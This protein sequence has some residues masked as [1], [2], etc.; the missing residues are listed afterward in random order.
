MLTTT[1]TT[2]P[3]AACITT[4]VYHLLIIS[5]SSSLTGCCK[6]HA[7]AFPTLVTNS[8]A[9]AAD[10]TN[11][12]AAA[13]AVTVNINNGNHSHRFN[14]DDDEDDDYDDK[15]YPE[16]VTQA[17]ISYLVVK[18]DVETPLMIADWTISTFVGNQRDPSRLQNIIDLAAGLKLDM[19]R[20]FSSHR[21]PLHM[22]ACGDL[23]YELLLLMSN[24]HDQQEAEED[25][26]QKDTTHDTTSTTTPAFMP[27]VLLKIYFDVQRFLRGVKKSATQIEYFFSLTPGSASNPRVDE[28]I[29]SCRQNLLTRE[30]R[31]AALDNCCTVLHMSPPSFATNISK[32]D[33][34]SDVSS[35]VVVDDLL[36]GRG[37]NIK[38]ELSS[39]TSVDSLLR[40]MI[41]IMSILPPRSNL[42][43]GEKIL[44]RPPTRIFRPETLRLAM[45]NLDDK[46]R[47]S[48]LRLSTTD[49]DNAIAHAGGGGN[50]VNADGKDMVLASVTSTDVGWDIFFQLDT[51]KVNPSSPWESTP[52]AVTSKTA[53]YHPQQSYTTNGRYYYGFGDVTV[54]MIGALVLLTVL[55]SCLLTC[56]AWCYLARQRQQQQQHASCFCYRSRRCSCT[57]DDV[58]TPPVVDIQNNIYLS[59]PTKPF[60]TTTD[61]TIIAPPTMLITD[62]EN[63]STN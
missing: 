2:T 29:N 33:G 34:D 50:V 43:D 56:I 58:M 54:L 24:D 51:K 61:T 38:W 35:V 44:I 1:T 59:S 4:I 11:V 15:P 27:S 42:R 57:Y 10:T 41:D 18:V 30:S 31:V 39:P 52:T 40:D 6:L 7:Q 20:K 46:L 60:R 8:T 14:D 62:E 55:V 22:K 48:G 13:A 3:L 25:R 21:H 26:H 23:A 36:G 49:P 9:T 17:G 19:Y 47:L 12:A 28:L 32:D 63:V 5:F 53:I 37:S 16:F 45:R